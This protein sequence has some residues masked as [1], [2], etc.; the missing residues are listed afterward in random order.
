M[1]SEYDD[2]EMIKLPSWAIYVIACSFVLVVIVIA[3]FLM[4]FPALNSQKTTDDGMDPN[5]TTAEVN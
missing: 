2:S 5:M 3:I 4:E 1:H